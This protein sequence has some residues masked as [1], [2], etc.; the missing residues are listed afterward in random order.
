MNKEIILNFKGPFIVLVMT[1]MADRES[2]AFKVGEAGE[3]IRRI[4]KCK[5]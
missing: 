5:G 2:Q 4:L 3:R 1:N